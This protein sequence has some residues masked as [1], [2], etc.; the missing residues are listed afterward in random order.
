MGTTAK[1]KGSQRKTSPGMTDIGTNR[2]ELY[3]GYC[4]YNQ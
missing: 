1:I 2:Q 3:I 4:K